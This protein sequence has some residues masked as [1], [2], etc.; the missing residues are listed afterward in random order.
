[1]NVG[2]DLGT[3]RIALACPEAGFAFSTKHNARQKR[4]Y[5]TEWDAGYSLGRQSFIAL[6]N[7]PAFELGDV[8]FYFERP[9]AFKSVKTAIGQAFSAGAVFSSLR[10]YGPCV[11]LSNTTWKKELV[12]HGNADKDRCRDWLQTH[13][14][15]L[16]ETCGQDQDLVDA[17]CIA[18]W[19]DLASRS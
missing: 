10:P 11:E 6:A 9:M 4:D 13:H 5:P 15:A 3:R 8:T 12:G 7:S 14:P 1:M 17:H 18:L 19:S 2:V 16:A